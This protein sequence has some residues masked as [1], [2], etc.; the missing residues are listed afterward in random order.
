MTLRRL[1]YFVAVAEQR[2]F[3]AAARTLHTAQP[4]LSTQ[5]RALERELGAELFDRTGR[6]PELS[7][8]GRALL[9][10][11]RRILA[12]YDRLATTA[13]RARDGSVGRLRLGLVPSATAGRLPAVLRRLRV[14]LPGLEVSLVEGRPPE[15]LRRLDLDDLD[16]VLLYTVV[17]GPAL[18]SRVL[19]TEPLVLAVPPGHRF[20]AQPAVAVADL[21]RE[22]LVLPARHGD[23]GLRER[24][25][26]L[27]AGVHVRVVQDDLWMVQTMVALVAAGLGC[28]VV[29]ASSAH[30]GPA[31]VEHRPFAD[32][33]TGLDLVASWREDRDHPPVARFLAA[34][35][36]AG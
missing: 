18:A 2:S 19:A 11:A 35:G 34:W 8:A 23:D 14:D 21:E 5:V 15:L 7:P 20:A 13:Q 33:R 1:E 29:P 12:A 32:A 26:A 25:S 28:A 17:D 31:E 22:P 6:T 36:A 10:E 30:V 27:L 24:T 4:P 3:S 16:V 9:P